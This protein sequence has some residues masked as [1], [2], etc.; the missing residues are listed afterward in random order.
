MVTSDVITLLDNTVLLQTHFNKMLV[1][2]SSM[3]NTLQGQQYLLLI[4]VAHLWKRWCNNVVSVSNASSNYATHLVLFLY[5]HLLIVTIKITFFI[6]ISSQH[7]T[8]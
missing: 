4:A 2:I 5:L 7:I 3:L 1:D 8:I 6:G